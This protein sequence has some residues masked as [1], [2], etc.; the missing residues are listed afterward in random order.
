MEVCQL[1]G[2]SDLGLV[3]VVL[4]QV[5]RQGA[6]VAATVRAVLPPAHRGAAGA[7]DVYVDVIV[8]VGSWG[9]QGADCGLGLRSD[10]GCDGCWARKGRARAPGS[11]GG[12]RRRLLLGIDGSWHLALLAPAQH[13]PPYFFDFFLFV[14]VIVVVIFLLFV[15]LTVG[16]A[17]FRVG[18]W[19]GR[20]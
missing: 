20:G 9:C 3:G 16:V 1:H 10:W 13:P 15:L 18:E 5:A 7:A 2:C 6:I 11:S 14:V 8:D 19:G 4:L 17:G 12:G